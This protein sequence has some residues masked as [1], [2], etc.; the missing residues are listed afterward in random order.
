MFY[1]FS[2]SVD[3]IRDLETIES[4]LCLKD[5]ATLAGVVQQEKDRVRKEKGVARSADPPLSEV[6]VSAYDKCKALLDQNH[7]VQT[8]EFTSGEVEIIKDMG[9]ITTKPQVYVI[10]MSQKSFIR[11]GNKWLPKIAQ[12]VK[13]HGGGQIIVSFIRIIC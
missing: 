10:N 5:S 3:P 13:T 4:E 2:V 8:G 11:K 6:F 7:P 1:T 9:L 12:W